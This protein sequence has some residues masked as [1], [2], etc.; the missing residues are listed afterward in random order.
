MKLNSDVYGGAAD[1]QLTWW[2]HFAE[3]GVAETDIHKQLWQWH[4]SGS[5]T[6][7]D[8]EQACD[9]LFRCTPDQALNA[10]T[11]VITGYAHK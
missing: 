3:A 2:T 8:K 5:Y 6:R 10:F 9:E 4:V 1:W 7:Q 11:A